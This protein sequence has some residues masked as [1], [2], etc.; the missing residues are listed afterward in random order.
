MEKNRMRPVQIPGSKNIRMSY[1]RQKDVLDM[2]NLIEVQ[3]NSYQWFVTEGLKEVFEDISPITDYTGQLS[4]EFVGYYQ[5]KAKY[6]IEKCKER[7]ATYAVPLK[8]SVRLHNKETNDYKQTDI[9]MGDLPLMTET[10]TFVINGA[11]RV[12]VSQLVRSPGIY[13]GISHDKTG[14][15]LFSCTVIPNRGAWLE[16]ETDSNDVF[17]VRV[18]RTRKV[19]ITVLIRSLGIGTN[20]EIKSLFGEEPKTLKTLEKDTATNY[21]E[22]LKKLYE[23]IRPGEPLSVDSAESLINSMFF[24]ARRYDLAKVGRYKFNKK[25]MLRNRIAGHV[26]AEDVTDPSTGEIL[27]QAGTKLT[28][29]Q[30]DEIQNAAV[31][32]VSIDT[33]DHPVKVLSNMM[34]DL[35]NFVDVDPKEVGITELVYYPKLEEILNMYD[36][37]EDIKTEIRR[38]VHDLIPKHITKEDILASIN[39]NIHLEYGL[40]NS[41]DIDHLGN[42]RIRAVGELLQNQYRIGLS[43]ME[44]VV[45]ERMTTQDMES[46]SP[47]TLINIKPITAAVKEFFGSSQ[48]SQFMDQHNPLSELTH[49]R[50]LS[51]LGPGGLSRDRAGF[52]VRDV[53]YSPW[54]YVSDRDP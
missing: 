54:A 1:A 32:S 48:L 35:R 15:R 31:A 6:S 42:R 53:H 9:F 16:Y 51:A 8:V 34:V 47:Q 27:F 25:L 12:I 13:Y 30:A 18:D 20:A 49:K 11:E 44:R 37:E 29:E 3:K 23:K 2:P 19:P 39:Y 46:I 36:D 45:R 24:D 38:S 10:G 41:D 22:G 7:D 26:L 52:E 21:Q 4:L 40:G 43:R 33:E 17:Y 14:K 50:R 28:R 5:E